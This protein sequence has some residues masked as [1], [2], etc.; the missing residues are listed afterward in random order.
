MLCDDT[1]KFYFLLEDEEE[2]IYRP[3]PK[4][5][6]QQKKSNEK[7]NIQPLNCC[8]RRKKNETLKSCFH[9]RQ[10]VFAVYDI[11]LEQKKI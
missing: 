10:S 1:C 3:S 11:A 6:R 2:E 5:D 9:L 7:H 4:K 8:V